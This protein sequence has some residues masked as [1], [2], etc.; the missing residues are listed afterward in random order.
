[1]NDSHI[2]NE[3]FQDME[4]FLDFMIT[5]SNRFLNKFR[6]T[7]DMDM[8]DTDNEFEI[9]S[10]FP[11]PQVYGPLID[12]YRQSLDYLMQT[13]DRLNAAI[14][15]LQREMKKPDEDDGIDQQ[16]RMLHKKKEELVSQKNHL[17]FARQNQNEKNN[18]Q[19][20]EIFSNKVHK[21]QEVEHKQDQAV[22]LRLRRRVDGHRVES[23]F[24]VFERGG[25]LFCREARKRAGRSDRPCHNAAGGL[26]HDC[27][28]SRG[29][30][31]G[32]AHL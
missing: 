10:W 16:I 7:F 3:D 4:K 9:P 18:V 31:K 11:N 15:Q 25:I 5:T 27:V 28:G 21:A 2:D 1:M 24:Q 26:V 29:I 8:P 20:A 14:D 6:Q 12:K 22:R 13:K 32:R 30:F 19:A 23:G 17:L